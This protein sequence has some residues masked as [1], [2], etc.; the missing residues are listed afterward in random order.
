MIGDNKLKI[1]LGTISEMKIQYP[2][3]DYKK[4][5]KFIGNMILND[6]N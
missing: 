4:L 1:L 6:T 5:L 2:K 3:H